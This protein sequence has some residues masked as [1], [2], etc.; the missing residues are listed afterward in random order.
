[1]NNDLTDSSINLSVHKNPKISEK[2]L[3]GIYVFLLIITLIV[4]LFLILHKLFLPQEV[5]GILNTIMTIGGGVYFIVSILTINKKE[6]RLRENSFQMK[7][8]EEHAGKL[9]LFFTSFM[10]RVTHVDEVINNLKTKFLGLKDRLQKVFED[11]TLQTSEV[12]KATIAIVELSHKINDVST[13]IRHVNSITALTKEVCMSTNADVHSLFTKTQE[14][15]DRSNQIRV[16]IK[17]VNERTHEIIKVVKG[18]KSINDQINILALNAAIEAARAGAAGRGFAVVA[19]QIRK[20]A[21]ETKSTSLYIEEAILTT[22][23]EMNKAYNLVNST[24]DIFNE[25]E[26]LVQDTRAAF[27]K[28]MVHMEQI[29]S[30]VDTVNDS[31]LEMSE[32]K[33]SATISMSSIAMSL[34]EKDCYEDEIR[35][36]YENCIGD[37]KKL[38][39]FTAGSKRLYEQIGEIHHV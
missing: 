12:E 22:Q 11:A 30:R 14:S 26:S 17:E 5:I 2:F 8:H 24:N 39:D 1:M 32:L 4:N 6:N 20:L 23:D 25:Q 31:I 15:V 21:I 33:D 34:M 37:V 9:G 18:I 36:E 10:Q 35:S 3:R 13:H 27:D 28:V 19:E 29:V 16:K 7:R 38:L